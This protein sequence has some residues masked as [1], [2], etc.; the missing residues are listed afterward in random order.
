MVSMIRVDTVLTGVVGSP[1]FNRLHFI[2]DTEEKAALCV[3]AVLTMWGT[4]FNGVNPAIGRLTAKIDDEVQVVDD[5]TGTV[6]DAFFLP[7]SPVSPGSV[8][9]D[10]IPNATQGLVRLNTTQFRNGRRV[11]GKIFFPCLNRQSQTAD[12]NLGGT[13][14]TLLEDAVEPLLGVDLAVW[15]RPAPGR[16]GDAVPVETITVWNEFAVLKSRRD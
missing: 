10:I 4:L 6:T 16:V 2:G 1:Y 8:T 14:P 15:S 9:V 12:G 3:G 5:A 13:M 7:T 11:R